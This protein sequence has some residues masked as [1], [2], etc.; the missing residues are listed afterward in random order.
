MPLISQ[1][2]ELKYG[3][4]VTSLAMVLQHA[5][6]KVNKMDLAKEIKKILLHC[7]QIKVETLFN[8]EILKKVLSE[9]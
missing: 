3:C 8:G 4:E 9:I 1:K 2:P 6:I 5:G 7:L